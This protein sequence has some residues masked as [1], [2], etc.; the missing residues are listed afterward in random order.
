M[1]NMGK[2]CKIWGNRSKYG[3]NEVC[4]YVYMYVRF[5]HKSAEVRC[6][7]AVVRAGRTRVP[8]AAG[9]SVALSTLLSSTIPLLAKDEK[10][11]YYC[12]I[13]FVFISA[14]ISSSC[15]HVF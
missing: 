3:G 8:A 12:Y 10:L 9:G 1:V 2:F 6:I 7:H 15:F 4:L 14:L 5:V 13:A 11:C